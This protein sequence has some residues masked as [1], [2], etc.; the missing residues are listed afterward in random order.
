M[1]TVLEEKICVFPKDENTNIKVPFEL[2]EDA[3][4]IC[5]SF[6]YSPKELN[7]IDIAKTK[8][9]KCLKRFSEQNVLLE[10]CDF[11]QYLPLVNLI[12]I[13]LDDPNGYRGCAH[14]HNPNQ[15]HMLSKDEASLGF[16]K[17]T[18]TKGKWLV[19]L[20]IYAVVTE[21]C[22]CYLKVE[23]EEE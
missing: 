16:S 4:K 22:D 18:I 19:I 8:I 7:D 23:I 1:K 2:I 3:K 15:K 12:T 11:E 14:R 20:H 6:S 13:S 10:E 21:S 9:K 5:I 17:G